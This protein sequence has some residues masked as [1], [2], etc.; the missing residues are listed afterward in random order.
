[1][2]QFVTTAPEIWLKLMP[3]EMQAYEWLQQ[4]LTRSAVFSISVGA[5][6]FIC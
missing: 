6:P 3:S 4:S 5:L 1:M 2:P